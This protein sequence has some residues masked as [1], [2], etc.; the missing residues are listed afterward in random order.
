MQTKLKWVSKLLCKIKGHKPYRF[1]GD[2]YVGIFWC[3]RCEERLFQDLEAVA[4][5]RVSIIHEFDRGIIKN[6]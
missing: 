6:H 1:D 2:A 5:K 4:E 3:D